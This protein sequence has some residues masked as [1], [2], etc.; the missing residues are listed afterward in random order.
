MLCTRLMSKL[1]PGATPKIQKDTLKMRP[2]VSEINSITYNLARHLADLLKHLVAKR[3]THSVN[4]KDFVQKLEK[5]VLE[6]EE[7]LTSFDATVLF[8]SVPGKEVV[9]MVIKR[10]HDNPT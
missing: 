10:A 8:I 9:L 4:L 3:D 5:I 6:D 7:V 2:I 1:N